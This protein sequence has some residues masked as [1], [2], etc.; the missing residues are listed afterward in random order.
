MKWIFL[1]IAIVAEVIATTALRY[2]EGFTK[3]IPSLIVATGYLIAFYFLSLTLKSM[4]VGVAYAIWSGVG[5]VLIAV[6]AF[7]FFKQ[8]LDLAAIIGL[9]LIVSGVAVINLF[10]T[11]VSH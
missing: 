11:S 1:I 8:K 5:T 3:L 7:F 9:L 6:V 2:S 4:S 10:S